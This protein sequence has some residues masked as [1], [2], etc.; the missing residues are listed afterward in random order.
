[1]EYVNKKTHSG[2]IVKLKDY[3]RRAKINRIKRKLLLISLLLIILMFIL[4][5]APFMQI[6]KINCIGNSRISSEDIIASSKIN[7]GDNIIR[8]SKKGAIDGIDDLAYV[9][10]VEIDRKFPS[11]LNIKIVECQV[12]ACVP[13]NDSFLYL[14]EEGKILE[15]AVDKPETVVP[16][17]TGV[18]LTNATVNTIVAFDN[19]TQL[20]CYK[21]L[22]QT[23]SNSRFSGIVTKI[24][25]SSTKDITITVN[26]SQDIIVGD[27][28]NLDYKINYL[29]AEVYDL[30]QNNKTDTMDLRYGN[31]NL[32]PKAEE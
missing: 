5:F 24:D 28:Q 7:I 23:L 16:V 8:I 13:F 27:I 15:T 2:K 18:N 17:I 3:K 30:P 1:M 9:K 14:D 4:L 10:K 11:T 20:D 12:Y 21:A 26:D 29:A 31:V 19:Q 22:I 6:K 32:I 25:L